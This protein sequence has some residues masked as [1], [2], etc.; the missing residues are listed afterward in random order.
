M[1][2]L[3]ISGA[4]TLGMEPSHRARLEENLGVEMFS[5]VTGL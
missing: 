1:L 2:S 5:G 3:H 4:V